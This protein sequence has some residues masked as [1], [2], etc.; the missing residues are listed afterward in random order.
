MKIMSRI[1][2]NIKSH[3]D[4]FEPDLKLIDVVFYITANWSGCPNWSVLHENASVGWHAAANRQSTNNF[5]DMDFFLQ[6]RNEAPAE[7]GIAGALPKSATEKSRLGKLDKQI[8]NAI[9]R[10]K[11]VRYVALS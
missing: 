6:R 9:C 2:I 4:Q 3:S 10:S 1:L 7:P 8:V 5:H 11:F